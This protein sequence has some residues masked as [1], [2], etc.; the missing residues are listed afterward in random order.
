MSRKVLHK[1]LMIMI[2]ILLRF[3]FILLMI[4]FLWLWSIDNLK[5]FLAIMTFTILKMRHGC[6]VCPRT[7]LLIAALK[8]AKKEVFIQSPVFNAWPIVEEVL[9]ACKRGVTVTLY[10]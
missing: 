2:L 7:N 1:L 4:L 10:V 3:I 6:M 5:L 8:L 9:N